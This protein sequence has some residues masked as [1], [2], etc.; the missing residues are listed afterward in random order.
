MKLWISIVVRTLMILMGIVLLVIAFTV[1]QTQ[2][3]ECDPISC[4]TGCPGGIWDV[5]YV[6]CEFSFP[7]CFHTACRKTHPQGC[8]REVGK[9]QDRPD[10]RT[11]FEQCCL[12]RCC[13]DGP[14]QGF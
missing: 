7:H 13:Y 4:S 2:A 8:Y 14:G 1:R 12:G 5:T 10:I 11:C 9:C 6:T 3:A